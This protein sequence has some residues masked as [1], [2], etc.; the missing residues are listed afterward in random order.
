MNIGMQ[1][2]N[3]VWMNVYVC[4]FVC[5]YVNHV[6]V[7]HNTYNFDCAFIVFQVLFSNILETNLTAKHSRSEKIQSITRKTTICIYKYIY[8]NMYVYNM[9]LDSV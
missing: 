8:M 9:N 4:I 5:L 1:K 7:G 6:Y 3:N 2:K